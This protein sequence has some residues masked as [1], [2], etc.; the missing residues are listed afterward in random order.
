MYKYIHKCKSVLH[1]VLTVNRTLGIPTRSVTNFSSAH[2]CDGSISIDCFWSA[3]GEPIE[4]LNSDSIWY[5]F[6]IYCAYVSD[7]NK[8][9]DI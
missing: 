5:V 6:D 8:N 7:G 2:D 3:S 4:E 9:V 1:I